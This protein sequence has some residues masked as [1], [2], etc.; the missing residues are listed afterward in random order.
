MVVGVLEIVLRLPEAQSLKEKRRVIKSLVTRIRNRFNVSV[1]EIDNQDRWQ[2]ATI[3]V[4]HVGSDK[5]FSNQVLD[6]V[7]NFSER[8]KALEVIDSRLEMI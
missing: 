4:A 3:A 5:A 6:Q 8:V 2:L 7:L 1:S